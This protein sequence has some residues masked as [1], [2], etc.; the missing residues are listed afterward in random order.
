MD[1]LLRNEEII[2][3]QN[4]PKGQS[5][6]YDVL[7]IVRSQILCRHATKVTALL[8]YPTDVVQEVANLRTHMLQ[9]GLAS[10]PPHNLNGAA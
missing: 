10:L 7:Y 6:T 4:P 1:S 8:S 2:L 3:S 5:T 9:S